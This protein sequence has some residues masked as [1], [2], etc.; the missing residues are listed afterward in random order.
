MLL[1]QAAGNFEI[2][3]KHVFEAS[4]FCGERLCQPICILIEQM[5]HASEQI[6]GVLC[7]AV[8]WG[9][10]GCRVKQLLHVHDRCPP[11]SDTVLGVPL[12]I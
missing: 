1:A 5:V 12:K 4:V 9:L 2:G 11:L 3:I 8:K 10:R 7:V 6:A